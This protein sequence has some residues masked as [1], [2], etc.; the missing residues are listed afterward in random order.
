MYAYFI[1]MLAYKEIKFNE[2]KDFFFSS[3]I[4]LSDFWSVLIIFPIFSCLIVIK[5]K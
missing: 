2:N 5:A 1:L 3:N 4:Y